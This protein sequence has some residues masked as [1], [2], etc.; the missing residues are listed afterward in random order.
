[1]QLSGY[2]FGE[3]IVDGVRH[4]KD[5]KI[6]KGKVVP[7]WWREQGHLV[8]LKDI[9]DI[10]E[11]PPH[12]LIIGTGSPGRLKVDP[13]LPEALGEKGIR[14]EVIPTALA[15]ERYAELVRLEGAEMVAAALHL[16]C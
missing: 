14:V 15:V 12:T 3:I 2:K 9:E 13:G 8:Q 1:M 11:S 6:I 16:T 4:T 7:R 5:L 10:L